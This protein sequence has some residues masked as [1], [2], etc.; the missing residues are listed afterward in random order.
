ML[1]PRPANP[2]GKIGALEVGAK[3]RDEIVSQRDE[4][5]AKGVASQRPVW[6]WKLRPY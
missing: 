4:L 3:G 1:V 2:A 5:P 6:L